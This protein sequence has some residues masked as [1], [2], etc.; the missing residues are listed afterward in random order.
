[1]L[2]CNYEKYSISIPGDL[3]ARADTPLHF[4]VERPYCQLPDNNIS[5][6][7]HWQARQQFLIKIKL[8]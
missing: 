5:L 3:K 1:M 2:H 4:P 8:Q 7:R 6:S